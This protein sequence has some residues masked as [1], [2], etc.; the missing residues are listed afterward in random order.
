VLVSLDY[1]KDFQIF[2]FA[3]K[4]TISMSYFKRMIKVKRNDIEFMSKSLRDVELK[5]AIMEKQDY[6]LVKSL[7]NFR[8]YVGYSKIVAYVPHLAIKD[9]L[10]QQDC[11]GVR[12]KWVEKIQ[13]YDLEI[14]STKLIKGQGLAQMLT[15]G[16]ETTLGMNGEN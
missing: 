5:Y 16:N 11:L 10:A 13:E 6:A 7:N 14:R 1:S 15:E 8:A 9:I 3:S 2:S 4:D 12:G